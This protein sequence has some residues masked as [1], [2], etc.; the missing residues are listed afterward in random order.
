MAAIFTVTWEYTKMTY[1]CSTFLF[2]YLHV[3]VL[4][5][6]CSNPSEVKHSTHKKTIINRSAFWSHQ[7]ILE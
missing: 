3:F 6:F 7:T 4:Y 2:Y 5:S 1:S